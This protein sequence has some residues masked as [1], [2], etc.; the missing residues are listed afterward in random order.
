NIARCAMGTRYQFW[1]LAVAVGFPGGGSAPVQSDDTWP[2]VAITEDDQAFTLTSGTITARVSKRS[3]DLVS[4]Q[5]KGQETLESRSGHA[6]G[7]WSHDTT[8]GKETI[9]RVTIDPGSN[10]GARGEVSVKGISAASRWDTARA[11]V[12]GATSP[13]TSRFAT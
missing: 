6:G 13:P 9:A 1:L 12:R 11:P 4:L 2:A 10:G 8:G 7:Y 3:G 5:Y